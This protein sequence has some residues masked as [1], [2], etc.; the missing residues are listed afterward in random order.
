MYWGE[1]TM[2]ETVVI[3]YLGDDEAADE[4]VSLKGM[5]PTS[6]S[7]SLSPT[8]YVIPVGSCLGYLSRKRCD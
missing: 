6:D 8:I 3:E 2:G 5:P 1:A 7:P 4:P